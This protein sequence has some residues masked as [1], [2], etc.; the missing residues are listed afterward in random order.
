MMD[1]SVRY[2]SYLLRLWQTDDQGRPVWRASLE[3]PGTGKRLG[4]ADLDELFKFLRDQTLASD[5]QQH[6]LDL[7][8]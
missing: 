6:V 5:G 4:F 3:S 8:E 2:F 7:R 1:K